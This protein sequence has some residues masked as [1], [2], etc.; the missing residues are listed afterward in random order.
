M[1][2]VNINDEC[3]IRVGNEWSP[4][5]EDSSVGGR[6]IVARMSAVYQRHR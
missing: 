2:D 1:H 3:G 4:T 5:G 6:L